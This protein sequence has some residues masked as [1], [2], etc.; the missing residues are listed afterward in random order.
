MEYDI[1]MKECTKCEENLTIDNF[2]KGR[3]RCKSCVKIESQK[4]YT[5]KKDLILVKNKEW[6]DNNKE[7]RKMKEKEYKDR[8]AV[9]IHIIEYRKKNQERIQ[10]YRQQYTEKNK[11][12]K[13]DYDKEY[14]ENNKE[15]LKLRQK[16]PKVKLRNKLSYEKNKDT[17]NKKQRARKSASNPL[18]IEYTSKLSTYIKNKV[19]AK[20]NFKA[21]YHDYICEIDEEF[22]KN[23]WDYQKGKCYISGIEMTH[24]T[25]SGRIATNL[26]FDQIKSGDGYTKNNV[27]LCCEFINLSK[28]QMSIDDFMTELMIAGENLVS[29]F[30]DDVQGIDKINKKA[31][32]YLLTLFKNKKIK[33]DDDYIIELYKNQGGRCAITGNNMTHVK[34]PS[35]KHRVPTN[36]SIDKIDPELGYVKEN[37]QLTCL[38]ANTGKLTHTTEL[39]R[40]LLLEAYHNNINGDV[41]KRYVHV[42]EDFVE[43]TNKYLDMMEYDDIYD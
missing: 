29:K 39:Y 19:S 40:K 22:I 24:K 12:K 14:R 11:E 43:I 9:K 1:E 37:V 10:K 25:Y 23:A 38:W 21:K 27:G 17:I 2:H 20:R 34:N 33:I 42:D 16:S 15:K 3:H 35:I 28:M 32:E 26:S 6:R 4:R 30:Y 41:P 7:Y 36:I 5:L 31:K 8:P 18:F 13:R